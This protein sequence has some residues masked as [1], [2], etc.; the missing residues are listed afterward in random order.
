MNF[1]GRFF[2][3]IKSTELASF[4]SNRMI[5]FQSINQLLN[6]AESDQDAGQ[7]GSYLDLE[8]EHFV[9]RIPLPN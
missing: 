8:S 1:S 2:F 3:L 4:L 6:K 7:I 5:N 9:N